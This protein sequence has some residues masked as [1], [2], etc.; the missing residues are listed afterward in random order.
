MGTATRTSCVQS[1]PSLEN[2]DLSMRLRAGRCSC[3][4]RDLTAMNRILRAGVKE[5]GFSGKVEA[6]PTELA[7]QQGLVARARKGDVVAVMTH[8]ERA[9]IAAWLSAAG[10]RPVPLTRRCCRAC[11]S[12]RDGRAGRRAEHAAIDR[13]RQLRF[14][15]RPARLNGYRPRQTTGCRLS[16]EQLR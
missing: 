7:A 16:L 8:V 9:E 14:G 10:F 3:D 11:R 15:Q 13:R 12:G 5:G 6:F 2:R 1:W 4:G